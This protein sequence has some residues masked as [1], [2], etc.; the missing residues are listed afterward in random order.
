MTSPNRAASSAAGSIYDIGYRHY[1]GARHGRWYAVW[2]LY[3]ESVRSVWGFGRPMRAKAAPFIIAG[4]YAFPAAIQLAFS[5]MISGA[6]ASGEFEG[7]STYANYF[8]Q[9]GFF[10]IFFCVAQAPELVCR[11]QRYQVLPLY[12]TRALGR[13]DYAFARLA[14]LATAIF[15]ALIAPMIILFVGDILM[16]PDTLTAIGDEWPKALPAIPVCALIGLGMA[17]ISLALSSFS[18]RRAYAAIGLLAYF[19]LMEAVP[20]IIQGVGHTNTTNWEWSDKLLLLCPLSGL[21]G[22]SEWFFGLKTPTGFPSTVGTDMCVVAA[23][24]SIVLFSGLLL[25]RYRRISA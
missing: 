19:L 24:V 21:S 10:M 20:A 9:M 4:I 7:L 12:F 17:A 15:A 5:S 16:K 13:F 1:E 6:V 14:A 23:L 18:P 2:S 8:V 3:V 11:D 25:F 22:A